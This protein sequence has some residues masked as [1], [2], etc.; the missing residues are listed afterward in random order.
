MADRVRVHGMASLAE[1]VEP[2]AFL[3]DVA[4]RGVVAE[5]FEG[6]HAVV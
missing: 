5:V 2:V 1:M 6:E 4:D 3:E